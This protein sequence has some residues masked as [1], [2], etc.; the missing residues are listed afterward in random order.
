MQIQVDL[1]RPFLTLFLA[2]AVVTGG[3][4][5]QDY[6]KLKGQVSTTTKVEATTDVANTDAVGGDDLSSAEKQQTAEGNIRDTRQLQLVLAH[7]EELLRYEVDV[8]RKEREAMGNKVSPETEEQFRQSSA[9][10]AAV[11]KDERKAEAFLRDSF[12]QLF[13]AEGRATEL[14]QSYH[15]APATDAAFIWPV[16]H[17]LGISAYF[18]DTAY[19]ARFGFEHNAID[20]PVY[21]GSDV[22]AAAAGTVKD[23]VDNGLGFNYVTIAH[24]GGIVTLYGH[25]SQLLVHPGQVVQAGELIGL[26]GG[27]PGTKGAGFSTGP[28]LHFGVR[29]NGQPVDPLQYLPTKDDTAE[30]LRVN[31]EEHDASKIGISVEPITSKEGN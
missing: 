22:V 28:H 9:N 18:H 27:R 21:Q 29:V 15:G 4:F 2:V 30:Q 7:K 10:L 8:L 19:K 13:E 12:E 16:S 24:D 31:K 14:A 26:S 25:L 3:Y 20:I 11:I 1:P 17:S 5:V 23:V 6:V